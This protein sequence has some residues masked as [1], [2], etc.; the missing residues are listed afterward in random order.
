MRKGAW[1]GARDRV[2]PLQG[3]VVWRQGRIP[4][5][6]GGVVWWEFRGGGG[7]CSARAA[8]GGTGTGYDFGNCTGHDFGNGTGHQGL[9]R[10][11]SET[12]WQRQGTL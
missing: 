12:G 9:A 6:E 2:P 3:G 10:R 8:G 11:H 4:V 5:A 7:A 1:S